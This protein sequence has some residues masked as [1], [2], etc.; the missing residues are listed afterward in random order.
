MSSNN[1]QPRRATAVDEHVVK[2]AARRRRYAAKRRPTLTALGV[3]GTVLLVTVLALPASDGN[4]AKKQVRVPSDGPVE[5][6]TPVKPQLGDAAAGKAVFRFETFGNEGFWTDAIKLPSGMMAAKTTP[7]QLL[8]L[9]LGLDADAM[10]A[11][12]LKT[13]TEQL[14]ADPSGKTAT[15][16]NDP[17]M[18]AK[19]ISANAVIGMVP[20]K[21][22]GDGPMDITRGDKVGATCALCHSIT[23]GSVMNL[24]TGGSIGHR[25]DGRTPHNLDFGTLVSLSANSRAFFPLLQLTLEANHG[26]TLGLAPQGLTDTSTEADVKAYLT[27]KKYYP[28]GMFD[29]SADGNGDPMHIQ[30]LFR[31]DLAFPYGS[32]GTLAKLDDFS[33][34]VYT[35][36]LDPTNLT[37]PGGRAFLHKLGGKAGDEIVAKYAAVLAATGVTG[38][39]YVKAAPPANPAVAGSE[40]Y[41]LGVRVDNTKLLDMNAYEV[42][43]QAP[44]GVVSDASAVARGRELFR[45]VGCTFCHNVDQSKPVP[46]FIV[47]MKTIFPGDD[48]MVLAKRE[49]PLNPVEHTSGSS[50][51]AKMAVTNASIRGLYRGVALPLLLDL[52]RKP[53]FLHDDSVASLDDLLNPSRGPKVPHP[54]YLADTR[55]RADMVAFLNSLG[56]E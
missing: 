19:L 9:G 16:L 40:E 51:D 36:L 31:Q 14:L 37:S 18:T 34:L 27:N 43:L 26:K 49:P 1:E 33:N 39:P 7:L 2:V 6:G 24:P 10:D 29:D 46:S 41:L 21:T 12:T 32:D 47:K 4:A 28:R 56:H 11:A 50:F 3:L 38:Y 23:D 48:P 54:F 5:P 53:V 42:S 20:K 22:G 35:A 17:G 15:L 44:P 25:Q 52:A 13:L 8:E 55:K 30:P 45:T